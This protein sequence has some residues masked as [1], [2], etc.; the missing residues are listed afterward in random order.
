M[1][2]LLGVK[3]PVSPCPTSVTRHAPRCDLPLT[4]R[5]ALFFPF[6]GLG[7]CFPIAACMK[8]RDLD[9]LADA[10]SRMTRHARS[11]RRLPS[12]GFLAVFCEI[13]RTLRRMGKRYAL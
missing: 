7:T 1:L 8:P 2:S 13:T 3:C 12:S 10:R 9:L 6:F 4:A 5:R 11:I